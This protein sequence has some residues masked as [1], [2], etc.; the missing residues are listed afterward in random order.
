MLGMLVATGARVATRAAIQSHRDGQAR[1][2]A[3][4]QQVQNFPFAL[5]PK[6]SDAAL[7]QDLRA[8]FGHLVPG[9]AQLT[10]VQPAWGEPPADAMLWLSDAPITVRYRYEPAA[11]V[12]AS[13]A[14]L[15][16]RTAQTYAAN[17]AQR[18]VELIPADAWLSTWSVEAAAHA[19][20]DLPAPDAAGADHEELFV[21]VRG[22]MVMFVTTRHPRAGVD[23]ITLSLFRSATEGS[24][25]WDAQRW[26]SGTTPWPESTFLEPRMLATLTP[27]R[28]DQAA[29]L[30]R[31]HGPMSEDER[32]GIYDAL[33]RVLRTAGPAWSMLDA[34]AHASHRVT[35]LAAIRESKLRAFVDA[36]FAEV[37]SAHDLR[38]LAMMIGRVSGA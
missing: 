37:R 34:S 32:A 23:P 14:D 10:A 29:W 31:E 2:A 9:R 30:A 6:A 4:R 15:A 11:F 33:D 25:C 22:G 26:Q 3:L 36:T 35:L 12:A 16:T 7:Y 13:A 21:L 5:T 19:E 24:M 8:T 27:Y 18:A 20:Y 17:R 28:S 1:A 38:G